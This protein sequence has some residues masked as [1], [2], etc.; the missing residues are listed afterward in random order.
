MFRNIRDLKAMGSEV[1]YR[2]VDVC[3]G[4]SVDQAIAAVAETCGRVDV[5]IHGA[6]I[7]VSKAL[8]SKTVEQ[9][10][11]VVA[12][13]VQGML[14]LLES[15]ER[16]GT[17]PRRVIGFGSVAGRFGNLAQTDY[18]AAND[19]LALRWA[20]H[21]LDGKASIIDWSPWSEIGMATRGSVQQTLEMAGIGFVNPEEAGNPC[22]EIARMRGSSEALAPW[23]RT[24]G[25][26]RSTFPAPA[27]H[28]S[29]I[30]WPACHCDLGSPGEYLRATEA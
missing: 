9:M 24:I 26:T 18:S 1:I 29:Q 20:D 2:S 5:V 17:P 3:D 16:H 12:V 22:S 8:R 28:G 7:D 14:N 4:Q 6:G 10:E 27:A 11:R 13:K 23:A 19:G 21:R 30:R 15:M 25:R